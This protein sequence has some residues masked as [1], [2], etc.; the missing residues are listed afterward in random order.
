MTILTT[1]STAASPA[2]RRNPF[3]QRIAAAMAVVIL[4]SAYRP[5]AVYDWFMENSLVFIFLAVLAFTYRRLPLSQTSYLLLF[6]F[7]TVHE[8]GAHYKYSDVPLGEWMKPWLHTQRNHYD[9]VSH[10]SYGLLCAYPM[11]EL[12]MRGAGVRSVWRYILPVEMT[13]AFSSTYEMLE[14]MMASILTPDRA[15]E[16]VGMQGD[17][18]DSQ[19]DMFMAGVGAVVAMGVVAVVRHRRTTLQRRGAEA[20]TE[21]PIA[22]SARMK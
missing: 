16:F 5:D 7:L 17:I 13:L 9:R 22:I 18:W 21:Q 4:I 19:K 14:A 2:F 3:L 11:Q 12:F 15:E 20:A 10:F 6:V 1:A 8:W